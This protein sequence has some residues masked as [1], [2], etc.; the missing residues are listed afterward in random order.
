MVVFVDGQSEPMN[1]GKGLVQA[2]WM[3]GRHS[4]QGLA[5]LHH[6][7]AHSDQEGETAQTDRQTGR[8]ETE[9][10]TE[11][12]ENYSEGKFDDG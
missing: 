10:E 1:A 3:T 9:R 7:V 6:A 8:R 5:H 12:K 11:K 4:E 2:G